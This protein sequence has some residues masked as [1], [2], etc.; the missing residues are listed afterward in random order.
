M[1]DR[2]GPYRA[3]RDFD[4][5]PEPAPAEPSGGGEQRYVVQEHHARSMHWDLRLEHEGT[6]ASWAVPKGIP[7][8]PERNHLAVRTEDH[9]LEYLDFHGEIP[10]GEY[11]AGTMKIWDRGTYELHKWRESEVMVT[12]HG[13]RLEG[14]YVLFRTGGKN[15]M[16]HRMDPPQD[17]DREPMPQRIEPMLARTGPLPPDDGRWAYE[18]KWDGIRAIGYAEGG[19]LKLESRNGN[20]ISSRY[21]E[22]RELGRALGSHEAVLDGEVVAFGPDG[23]PSFQVLQSRMHV[24]SEAAQRRLAAAHPVAYVIFDLLYLDGRGLMDLRYDERRAALL[25]LGLTGPNWQTPAHRVG[26]GE[27]LLDATRAQGLEGIIAKRLDCPYVPGRRSQGWVKV[28]NVR[29]TDVVIGGW[30]GGEGGRT[31]RLGAL[32]VGYHDEGGALRY[33]GRVGTGFDERELDRLGK[34]LAGRARVSSPF[35]G[36]QPPKQTRFV[37]PDLV[38]AVDYSEWTSAHTL[39]QPSYKGLRE[40]IPPTD[41]RGPEDS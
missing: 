19:R 30:L 23:K 8:D 15:W 1:A 3:K 22:L 29:R 6:L 34:L 14:R 32:V 5:T 11:G 27:A 28:K 13:E 7:P 33:A 39:R 16:I 36:R 20:D 26:D 18:V 4:A 35:Q 9:P 24:A 41:V 38:A 25:E 2:L 40:D 10:A 31:G 17:A 37:E 12:F 21:P